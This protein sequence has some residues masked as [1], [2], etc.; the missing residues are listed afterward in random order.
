MSGTISLRSVFIGAASVGALAA[1]G[2]ATTDP[3]YARTETYGPP[4]QVAS[5]YTGPDRLYRNGFVDNTRPSSSHA[6]VVT[7]ARVLAAYEGLDGARLA[8]RLYG[9]AQA[10]RLDGACGRFEKITQGETLY[11]ISQYCDVPVE[12]LVDY[13]PVVRN[14]R[15][16]VAGQI[17]EIPQIYNPERH[18]IS[19]A[20][21]DSGVVFASW[22][23]VQP[24]DTLNDIAARHL[25]SST[26]I[27]NLNPGVAWAS[28]PVGSQIRLP[29]VG[30]G[31]EV[32]ATQ[33][34]PIS[35]ALP[36][37]YGPASAYR[38]SAPA[39]GSSD[40]GVVTGDVGL[41]PYQM[42]PAQKAAEKGA[43]LSSL[44]VDRDSVD[45]GADVIV[46]ASGLPAY[47]DVSIY[48]GA[49]GRDMRYVKTVRTDGAGNFSEPVRVRRSTDLGGVIFRATVDKTGEK[50]QSPRV[51]V[52]SLE[53]SPVYGDPM[54]EEEIAY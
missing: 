11:E 13:N 32:L 51:A 3:R 15:H 17:I 37:A 52:N 53:D 6:G 43:S 50:L 18:A 46:S 45:P 23:V 4:V 14:P 25:V 40:S 54:G 29:A 49:N 47:T 24:G 28:L 20:A 35:G 36:Y 42:T 9:A 34:Q 41:M 30:T 44:I 31:E 8:H 12:M 1:A 7:E 27:A 21:S 48:R 39:S 33:A 10:E 19:A 2:C 38:P 16:V 22:Y 5:N 26:S